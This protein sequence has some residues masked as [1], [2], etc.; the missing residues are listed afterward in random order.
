LINKPAVQDNLK[1]IESRLLVFIKCTLYSL[2]IVAPA[3]K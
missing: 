3:Q 1:N 2:E